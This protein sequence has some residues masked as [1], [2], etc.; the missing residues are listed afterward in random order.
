MTE[1]IL[2]LL[3]NFIIPIFTVSYQFFKVANIHKKQPLSEI[4]WITAL[5]GMIYGIIGCGWGMALPI[6]VS[7]MQK[8]VLGNVI[9]SSLFLS[10]LGLQN[11]KQQFK[12]ILFILFALFNFITIF[13]S[14]IKYNFSPIILIIILMTY[15]LISVYQFLLYDIGKEKTK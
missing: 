10:Y 7:W 6:S 8:C 14:V 12:K 4:I 11:L 9:L 2:F 3:W 1:N 13:G 5:M 15:P